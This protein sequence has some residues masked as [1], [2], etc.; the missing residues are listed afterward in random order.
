MKY[1]IYI[2]AHK[3]I[4]IFNLLN[5]PKVFLCATDGQAQFP[6]RVGLIDISSQS[7][8][9]LGSK[10]KQLIDFIVRE[11]WFGPS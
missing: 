10:V 1:A 9:N 5:L 8:H 7:D 6:S 11:P 2:T 4:A 3:F